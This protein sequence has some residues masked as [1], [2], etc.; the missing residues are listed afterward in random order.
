MIWDF[1]CPFYYKPTVD[2]SSLLAKMLK[3]LFK[4][5]SHYSALHHTRWPR[6]SAGENVPVMM[7]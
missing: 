3:E 1:E 7:I 6:W 2:M 4:T 5:F